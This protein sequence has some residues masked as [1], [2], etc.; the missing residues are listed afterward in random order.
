MK[1]MIFLFVLSFSFAFYSIGETVSIIDQN[2]E[3]ES[4]YAGN[5]YTV[6][7]WNVVA[8]ECRATQYDNQIDCI[9]ANATNIWEEAVC[10]D[11]YY[12]NETDC[13]SSNYWSLADWNGDTNGGTYNVVFIEMSATW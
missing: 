9:S 6:N 7:V 2:L 10:I 8:S 5:G 4:C 12:N 11:T 13:E 1:K 3:K